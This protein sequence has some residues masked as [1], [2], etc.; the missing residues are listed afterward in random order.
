[1]SCQ[2][3]LKLCCLLVKGFRSLVCRFGLDQRFV[4]GVQCK[5]LI[6][7]VST[8]HCWNVYL[9]PERKYNIIHHLTCS[10]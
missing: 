10:D 3:L 6:H 7:Y 8:S 5:N 9:V 1:M 4:G 2:S